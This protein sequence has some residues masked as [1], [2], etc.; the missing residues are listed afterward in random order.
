MENINIGLVN[1]IISN[2]LQ[3]AYVLN[4]NN[5][6]SSIVSE[7]KRVSKNLLETIKSSPLL[8]LE[9]KVINNIENKVINNEVSATRY[10][11]NNISLFETYTLTELKREREKLNDFVNENVDLSVLNQN[12]VMLYN[13]INNLIYESLKPNH[14]VDIDKIHESFDYVLNHIKTPLDQRSGYVNKT[15]LQDINIENITESVIERAI[16]KFNEK[17]INNLSESDKELFF[18]LIKFNDTQKKELFEN[19]KTTVCDIIENTQYD[20]NELNNK[21]QN[22]LGKVK[23]MEY[24]INTVNENIIKLHELKNNIL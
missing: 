23:A 24:D 16:N 15:Q 12:K 10:I 2:K 14:T 1:M 22:V 17:Y 7:L 11:D 21:K 9:F 5:D 3:Q 4:E 8:Q 13:S 19:Y 6:H 20:V 18:N